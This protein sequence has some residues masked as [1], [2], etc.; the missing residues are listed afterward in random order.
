[1]RRVIS[2]LLRTICLARDTTKASVTVEFAIIAIPFIAMIFA[3]IE[4][5]LVFLA[6]EILQSAVVDTSRAIMTGQSIKSDR[7]AFKSAICDRAAIMVDCKDRLDVDVRTLKSLQGAGRANPYAD[8]AYETSGW[9]FDPGGPGAV[10][11]VTAA[12][13]WPISLNFIGV[14]LADSG[15]KTRLLMASTAMKNEQY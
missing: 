14:S 5:A 9:V 15:S 13:R 7:E 6:G 10:V 4:T 8:G 11:V 2:Q 12:Y 3:M 1:M